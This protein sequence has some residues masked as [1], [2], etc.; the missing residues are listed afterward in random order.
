MRITCAKRAAMS[1]SNELE[2]FM[3]G[4]LDPGRFPHREHVR[5]SFEMLRVYDFPESVLRYSRALQ[6]MTARVGKPEV[7][8]QTITVAFLALVAERMQS[9][10]AADFASFAAAHPDLLD[11]TLLARWYSPERLA[12]E[13]ARRVFLLPEASR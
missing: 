13:A 6:Q 12:S 10:P 1:D 4:C 8:N 2:R 3:S 7:F 9:G 11:R 5:M